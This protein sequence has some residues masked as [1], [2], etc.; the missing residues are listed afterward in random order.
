MGSNHSSE[1][2]KKELSEDITEHELSVAV[3][4]AKEW[5]SMKSNSR[6]NKS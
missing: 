6:C 3:I 1:R 5:R 2:I 4:E